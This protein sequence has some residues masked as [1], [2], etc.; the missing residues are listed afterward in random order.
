MRKFT[1]K[2]NILLYLYTIIYTFFLGSI[3][4]ERTFL[5]IQKK[6]KNTYEKYKYKIY[7]KINLL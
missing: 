6:Y 1:L 4:P 5:K 3:F 7:K 2:F